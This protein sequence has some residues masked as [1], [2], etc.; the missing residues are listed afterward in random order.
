MSISA[1]SVRF[2][3]ILASSIGAVL[4]MSAAAVA[5][6]TA[7][8]SNEEPQEIVVTGFRASLEN[9]LEAKRDASGIVDV[10][11]AEDIAKFP[12]ANL[13]ESIQRIPG[14]SLSRSEGGEGRQITVRGLNAGFTRVRINGIEGVVATGASDISGSTNRG[15]GFDFS[16]FASELFNSVDVRKSASADVEE[17]SLGATVDLRT[18]RPFD[19]D[20]FTMSLGG[21]ALYNDLSQQTQPRFTALI[22]DTRGP[23]GALVSYAYSRRTAVEE[24]YEAVELL[25]ANADGGFC[26]P[27]GYAPQSP[28]SDAVRGTDAAN[29][30]AGQP[31]TSVLS[32][33]DSVFSRTDNFGGINPTPAAGTGAF[34]PRIPRYRRS[35]TEY[36]RQGLTASL[37]WHPDSGR[38]EVNL[39]ALLGRFANDRYDNYI[40][41]I[42]FGRTV[43]QAN[44][45]PHSSILDAHFAADGS[46]DYG[47]FDGVDI[48]TEG[49]L[50]HYITDFREYVLSARH[51]FTDRL[52]VDLLVGQSKSDLDEPIRDTVQ[53]DALNVN[54]YSFDFRT[55]N[56]VPTLNHVIDVSNP[57]NFTFAPIDSN[58]GVHGQFTGRLLRTTNTL[59]TG[60][61]NAG[62]KFS[63]H[64]RLRA[65]YSHRDNEWD[66]YEVGFNT[67][68]NNPSLP[69]GVTLASVSRQIDGFGKGLGGVGVPTSWAAVDLEK[70]LG[71]LN[72]R[73]HCAAVQGSSYDTLN[74]VI[75][76]VEEKIK[77]A[78]A[79]VD[80]NFD[81][82]S[83][84][85]RG[86][87]GVRRVDTDLAATGVVAAGTG[88]TTVTIDNSYSDTL[89]ALNVS[90][91][92]FDNVLLRL[93]AAKTLARP[94]Y[95]DLTP[96]TTITAQT[97]TVAIG[98]PFLDP[99]RA[100]TYDLQ[101]EWYF[102]KGALLSVGFFHKDIKS[103]I[104]GVSERVPYNTLGLGDS[105][106]IQGNPPC[107]ITGGTPACATL[108]STVVTV[109]RRVNTDG[110]PL[111]GFEIGVQ[112]P[113]SFLP[114]MWRNLGVLANYTHV[115][116]DIT[117]ITRV[118]NPNTPANELLTQNANFTG[119]SPNAYNVTLYYDNARFSARVSAAYRDDYLLNVLGDVNG[120]DVTTVDGTTNIDFSTSYNFSDQLRVSLEGQNLTDEAFRYG[121]D[122]ERNDTLLY[123]HSG[124][125]FTLG[126]TYKF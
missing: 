68:G 77:A 58:L 38:T 62:W 110:G 119:L 22:S 85:I 5:Q 98:N 32:A 95:V 92:V 37:Q 27:L 42:S 93:S 75:R 99:I 80:F 69:A 70:F 63:D 4:V 82:G 108:P 31:R 94:E 10:I 84:P 1:K 17:G 53:F 125:V 114:G 50:D 101:A 55:N 78:H 35:L 59:Q 20:G 30:A 122:S 67:N 61:L 79:M 21:Q 102:A 56:N 90:A 40:E 74:Q 19:F 57:L 52:S 113:F 54:G 89:P 18:S 48:R 100:T 6:Q 120:H 60:E 46:W 14:V 81:A 107:S 13:A 28:P 43:A 44:G 8:T 103:F 87:I 25:T 109:N 118:D 71:V 91:E 49:L 9:A 45:K 39:D 23:F 116:S 112:A 26:S 65:G 96:T 83:I 86:N 34:A 47:R 64:L 72:F 24:G 124:R 51:D 15:R 66:N 115:K 73:C 117:Y 36:E 11:R 41:A 104:Q 106:L 105:L 12:D 2:A 123:V 88:R 76:N 33:Y 121:R 3:A 126:V 97:Q 16:V 111:D 29:C 7:A